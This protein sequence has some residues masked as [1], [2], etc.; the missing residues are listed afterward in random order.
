M[1]IAIIPARAGSKRI[2]NKNI[3]LFNGKPIIAWTIQNALKSKLFDKVVV[4]TD[5]KK[6]AKIA[7]SYGAEIPFLRSKKISDD[8]TNIGE[9]IKDTL[10]F[11]S[12]QKI[13]IN[14][15]CLLYATAP[16]MNKNDLIKG[17]NLIKNNKK[18]DFVLSISKFNAP[19]HRAL[20]IKDKKIIPYIK[21]NV[22]KRSQDLEDLYYDNAQ[23]TFGKFTSWIKTKHSFFSKTGYIE[24]P[25]FRTQDIDNIDDWKR[26]EIIFKLLKKIK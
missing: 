4:S 26:A 10:A 3:K 17:Y 20:K 18:L 1:N 8:K 25:S 11:L 2:K 19:Y 7:K 15:A 14:Y 21:K 23:F 12:N 6:I 16:L 24:I 22:N 9:V 13:K 5:S